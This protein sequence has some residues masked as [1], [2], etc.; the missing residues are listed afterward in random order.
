MHT[1]YSLRD[2]RQLL[3][4]SM[5]AF[6]AVYFMTGKIWVSEGEG[7]KDIFLVVVALLINIV[8]ASNR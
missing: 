2:C 4:N 3:A 8:L 7:S 6:G 5:K 1:S